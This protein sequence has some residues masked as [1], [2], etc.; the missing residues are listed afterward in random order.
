M[1]Y[2]VVVNPA[3]LS[4]GTGMPFSGVLTATVLLS[5][6]MTLLMGL[7][8][9]LPFAV[10]PGMG[11]NAFFALS[12]VAGRQIP[13]PIALGM[14]F[15]AGVLFLLVSA[16]P[17]RV[18][19]ARA[20]PPNLRLASAAGIGI[21]LTF[22]GFKNAGLVASD[23]NTLVRLAKLDGKALLS[24]AGLFIMVVM[25]RKRNPLS[26]LISIAVVTLAAAAFGWI[27]APEKWLEL[28]DFQSV[29][30]RLD[31]FG[32]LKLAFVPAILAVMFTDLFD[33]LSTFVG[34][35]TATGLVDR[36][37]EP[38]R[39]KEGLVVDAIATLTAGLAGTSS[40]TAFIES[41]A[42]IEA[43]GRTGLTAV[44]AALCFLPCFFFAP[45]AGMVPVYATAPALIL[46]G[47]QMFRTV[48]ELKLEKLEDLVPSFLTLILIPLT[49]SITQG[50]L[51]GIV[52]HTVLYVMVGRRREI[53]PTLGLLSVLCLVLLIVENGNWG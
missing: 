39:L 8:A 29:F 45:V 20:I 10:A 14:V 36:K 28:P 35:S 42:G 34:V 47:A 4:T 38:V 5:F 25:V 23:P 43:G 22:I 3:I 52:A 49:F 40:G 33:S 51:W 24:L 53:S 1:S 16:T 2:I 41:A 21:F 7:Y 6:S 12:L 17:L 18:N 50:I 11:V 19:I 37:G 32:S 46:V 26:F 27:E 15:W 31:F 30:L 13:W 48:L 44:F 9:K